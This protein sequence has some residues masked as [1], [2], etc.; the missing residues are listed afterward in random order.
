MRFIKTDPT[1]EYDHFVINSR[2]QN[3]IYP[4]I[5][6]GRTDIFGFSI[7]TRKGL[8]YSGGSMGGSQRTKQ[9]EHLFETD[10]NYGIDGIHFFNSIPVITVYRKVIDN[11]TFQSEGVIVVDVMLDTI[12]TIADN[13]RIMEKGTISII[14]SKGNYLY[15]PNP[16]NWGKSVPDE[17]RQTI[18]NLSDAMILESNSSH[19]KLI[20]QHSAYTGLTTVIELSIDE[21][22][23]KIR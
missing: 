20:Y 23:G 16:D 12:S 10:R 9:Y 19:S 7:L 18:Q 5:T 21:F 6:F 11:V 14:D 3:E 1:N 15:H 13:S 2:I 8:F 17:L 22:T 4:S